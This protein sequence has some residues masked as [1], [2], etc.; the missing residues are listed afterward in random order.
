MV[1]RE[2]RKLKLNLGSEK[3]A[4]FVIALLILVVVTVLGLAI[5]ITSTT[6]I[7]ISGNVRAATEALYIAEGGMEAVKSNLNSSAGGNFSGTSGTSNNTQIYI[8]DQIPRT[9]ITNPLNWVDTTWYN[10]TSL[11]TLLSSANAEGSWPLYKRI[12]ISGSN[13]LITLKRPR[14]F[15]TNPKKITFPE[16]E[17]MFE[18]GNPKKVNAD[19]EAEFDNNLLVFQ[20]FKNPSSPTSDIDN[21]TTDAIL[22]GGNGY[23]FGIDK[24]LGKITGICTNDNQNK[25]L[26]IYKD[27]DNNLATTDWDII[28]EPIINNV[29]KTFIL[30]GGATLRG[31]IY[32]P[33]GTAVA[34]VRREEPV[35]TKVGSDYIPSAITTALSITAG[36][37]YKVELKD[38][39]TSL[40]RTARNGDPCSCKAPTPSTCTCTGTCPCTSIFKWTSYNHG[41]W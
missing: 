32:T 29:N 36:Q 17:S 38:I 26:I 24:S 33:Y 18:G 35:V 21:S 39:N 23:D 16:S 5:L 7:K 9:T 40:T 31:K 1:I 34:G 2:A 41:Q 6:E 11:S 15:W 27:R 10:N 4:A 37:I 13:A 25:A 20:T 30:Q 8:V 19:I 14:W 22:I 3:G 12:T 28:G